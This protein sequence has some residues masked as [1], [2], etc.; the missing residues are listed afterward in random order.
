MNF[1]APY[2]ITKRLPAATVEATRPKVEAALKGV[3]PVSVLEHARQRRG[4]L[5]CSAERARQVA[6]AKAASVAS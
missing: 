5:K 1:E 6:G 4:L 2:A 3:L